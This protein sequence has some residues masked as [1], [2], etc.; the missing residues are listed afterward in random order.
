MQMK[1]VNECFDFRALL[2]HLES[3]Q[4]VFILELFWH[5]G[6]FKEFDEFV[7]YFSSNDGFE[8][9]D[10]SADICDRSY[11]LLYHE[12]VQVDYASFKIF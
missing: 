10:C 2:Q 4:V 11:I 8:V 12:F 1:Y 9:F 3:F 5:H 7:G 6:A